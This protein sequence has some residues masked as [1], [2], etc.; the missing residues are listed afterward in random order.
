MSVGTSHCNLIELLHIEAVYLTLSHSRLLPSCPVI[1][2]E[3][4]KGLLLEADYCLIWTFTAQFLEG[5]NFAVKIYCIKDSWIRWTKS[6]FVKKYFYNKKMWKG[7]KS[8]FNF[9]LIVNKAQGSEG[10]PYICL[11]LTSLKG[12][13]SFFH[14]FVMDRNFCHWPHFSYLSCVNKYSFS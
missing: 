2:V 6:V 13:F 4:C 10:N 5:C 11:I 1:F 3:V 14:S 8:L 12:H 7:L 9:F